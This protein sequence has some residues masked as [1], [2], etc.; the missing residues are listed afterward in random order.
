MDPYMA[1]YSQE[2]PSA[3]GKKMFRGGARANSFDR[4]FGDAGGAPTARSYK[5]KKTHVDTGS[6]VM[7]GYQQY[8]AADFTYAHGNAYGGRGAPNKDYRS[9]GAPLLCGEGDVSVGRASIRVRHPPG[10]GSSFSLG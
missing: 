4:V 8:S 2:Q 10:G 9:T 3:M 1:R 5:S 7:S 6:R